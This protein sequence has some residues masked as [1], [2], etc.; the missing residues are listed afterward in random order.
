MRQYFLSLRNA[1]PGATTQ[2]NIIMKAT[3]DIDAIGQTV[4]VL[5]AAGRVA[6]GTA[7]AA[8]IFLAVWPPTS[9]GTTQSNSTLPDTRFG[10]S[11]LTGGSE[12]NDRANECNEIAREYTEWL[13][14]AHLKAGVTAEE[15]PLPAQ[16]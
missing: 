12:Q 1:N 3:T 11:S 9:A 8:I 5:R 7:L 15:Q 10:G 16:F 14:A 4:P 13:S 2:R 6:I